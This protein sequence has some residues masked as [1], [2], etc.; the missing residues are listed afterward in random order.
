MTRTDQ[1]IWLLRTDNGNGIGAGDDLQGKTYGLLKIVGSLR[2][3][4]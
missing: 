4:S 3:S 2:Q 1:Q